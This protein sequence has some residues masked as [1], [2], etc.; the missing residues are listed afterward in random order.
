MKNFLKLI[1][2]IWGIIVILG[3]IFFSIDYNRVKNQEKPI[4]CIQNPAGIM[5]DGGTIEYFGLGYKVIDFHTLAGYDD[6]KIG[7]W[8]MDY[9]DFDEEMKEYEEKHE[10]EMK[11]DEF[12]FNGTITQVE[13]NLF[14]V[15]PDENEEIRKSSDLIMVGKLKIDTDTCSGYTLSACPANGTCSRCPTN[16][17]KLRLV[18]CASPYRVNDNRTAC[19]QATCADYGYKDVPAT[20][21]VCSYVN[22]PISSTLSKLCVEN[23]EQKVTCSQLHRTYL[24]ALPFKQLCLKLSI[25]YS[26]LQSLICY[27]DCQDYSSV[28]M[29]FPLNCSSKPAHVSNFE[30][31]SAC[32]GTLIR[33]VWPTLPSKGTI[34]S[35]S[36]AINCGSNYCRIRAC[37]DGY[38]IS[39]NSKKCLSDTCPSGY[40]KECETGTQGDPQYTEYGTACYRCKAPGSRCVELGYNNSIQWRAKKPNDGQD[41]ELVQTATCPYASNYWMGYW[42]PTT[43]KSPK[44]GYYLYSDKTC[45]SSRVTQKTVIGIIFSDPSIT[46][47][48]LAVD[49][50]SSNEKWN[51]GST[52]IDTSRA[53]E[54]SNVAT[55]AF[56]IDNLADHASP[57]EVDNGKANTKII[58]K[59]CKGLGAS[60]PAAEVAYE[61]KTA[62]TSAGDWYL[63]STGELKWLF[64]NKTAVNKSLLSIGSSSLYETCYIWSSEERLLSEAW[65]WYEQDKTF[66]STYKG[67]IYCSYAVLDLDQIGKE[68]SCSL[69]TCP[70][71][72]LTSCPENGICTPCSVQNSQC[73]QTVKFKL[74]SCEDG[75]TVSG[76]TCVKSTSCTTKTCQRGLTTKPTHATSYTTCVPVHE[77]CSMGVATYT[78]TACEAGYTLYFGRC[79]ADC[80]TY[81]LSSCPSNASC[82]SCLSGLTSKYKIDS[83][84][85]GYTISSDGSSC[86]FVQIGS[87]YDTCVA[88]CKK[89]NPGSLK[90]ETECKQ[91]AVEGGTIGGTIKPGFGL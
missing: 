91:I 35:Q 58:Y 14:F 21:E 68:P 64:D 85:S 28:L 45:S 71:Y 1:G 76:N 2:V 20:N 52:W 81:T 87:S 46:S 25:K 19:R 22:V 63:P 43:C 66:V 80:S 79:V 27:S 3:I 88:N 29:N 17:S 31:N 77:D 40:Y 67:N 16:S 65:A 53:D 26:D 5:L 11:K 36:D 78:A 48:R 33:K 72:T 61:Y 54:W 74:D 86:I 34:T 12:S 18:S 57:L 89:N 23:C 70:G 82:S 83:C 75:Y 4:F 59:Y 73:S 50:K 49:L 44:P 39:S 38:K 13:E 51:V 41:Y 60:C 9:D 32:A 30:K 37:E 55:S 6:I 47:R 42:N 56:W 15:V 69:K 84:N 90:C 8:F 7:T 24:S 62:G 10:K